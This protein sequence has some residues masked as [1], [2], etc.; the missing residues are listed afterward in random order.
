MLIIMLIIYNRCN[1]EFY[2]LDFRNS[3]ESV[4]INDKIINRYPNS[5]NRIND[6]NFRFIP[7]GVTYSMVA[8]LDSRSQKLFQMDA[9]T[10]AITTAS[11]LDR[12]AIDVHYLRVVAATDASS[13]TFVNFISYTTTQNPFQSFVVYFL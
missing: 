4:I 12:E 5:K 8:I 7:T 13:P 11:R 10:G 1:L 9:Q 3:Y 2:R 6:Y